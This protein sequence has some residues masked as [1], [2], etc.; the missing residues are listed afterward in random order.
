[1]AATPVRAPPQR[2]LPAASNNDI[3]MKAW[4][5]VG[6][7]GYAQFLSSDHDFL[8]VRRFDTLSIRAVLALQD[9]VTNLETMLAQLDNKYSRQEATDVNNGT[10]RDDMADRAALMDEL[11]EALSR[12]RNFIIQETAIKQYARAPGR[13]VDSI[14]NWH[15][16]HYNNA[17]NADELEYLEEKDLICL[18]QKEKT[19]IRQLI[20][21]SHRFRTLSLWRAKKPDVPDYDSNYVAYYSD[22]RIDGFASLIIILIGLMMLITPIWVLSVLQDPRKKLVVITVFVTVFLVVLSLAMVAKPFEAL[23]A[24]AAYAAVL[25]V[26]LQLGAASD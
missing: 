21:K 26:F 17:I 19:P 11:I 3:E 10:L 4:K 9:K 23:A 7:K 16:N 13:D 25:M 8:I 12:Y 6:Y 15:Y 1:M 20:D 14:K 2:S 5:H 22:K 24:T 18:V